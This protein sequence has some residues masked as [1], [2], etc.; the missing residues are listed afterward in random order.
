M[1]ALVISIGVWAHL[2]FAVALPAHPPGTVD[3][4]RLTIIGAL[5]LGIIH[6]WVSLALWL[7]A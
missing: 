3:A 7:I 1:T 5:W 6:F 4:A 2:M